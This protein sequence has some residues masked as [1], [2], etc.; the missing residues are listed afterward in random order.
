VAVRVAELRAAEE[1]KLGMSREKWL[2][3]LESMTGEH[4][5][6]DVALRALEQLG[7][8]LGYYAP[9]RQEIDHRIEVR[10]IGIE[11]RVAAL[12]AKRRVYEV[13]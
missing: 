5:P 1:K 8:A 6:D 2:A 7:K 13:P 12:I 4:K 11:A 3:R 10:A 9:Q